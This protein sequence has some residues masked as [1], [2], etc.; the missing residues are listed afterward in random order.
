MKR[1]AIALVLLLS[2]MSA[3]AAD[4]I[5]DF[6]TGK[7]VRML[8]GYGPGGGYDIYGR[9]V[10]E[11]LPKHLPG[12]PSIVTENMPGAGSFA[13]AK[14]I[15]NVA[16]KDGTVLASLA[17]TFALDSAVGGSRQ[18]Q[19]GGLPLHRPRHHQHRHRRGAHV[20]RH[21][22]DR[23]CAHQAIHGGGFRPRLDHGHLCGGAE[24]LRGHQV[25]DRDRL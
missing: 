13:A 18:D 9:L 3:A 25:Q 10:A 2:A 22:V 24:R 17:Q 1:V 16:P 19:R 7:T 12:H 6:Y 5:A 8:V 20:V 4:P 11:F 21:Q 15:A 23:R 14:Y